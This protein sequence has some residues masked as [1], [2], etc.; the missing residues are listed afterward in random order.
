MKTFLLVLCMVVTC[1]MAS[2]A[3]ANMV[4]NG[5]LEQ[6]LPDDPSFGYSNWAA[7]GWWMHYWQPYGVTPACGDFLASWTAGGYGFDYVLSDYIPG[8]VGHQ[9]CRLQNRRAGKRRVHG[10][11]TLDV[12]KTYKVTYWQAGD[13]WNGSDVKT[14]VVQA[15]WRYWR[16]SLQFPT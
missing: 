8:T 9:V 13:I 10:G 12:N 11:W 16:C 3:G 1:C 2:M 4:A 15:M 6:W 7:V 14:L 5:D